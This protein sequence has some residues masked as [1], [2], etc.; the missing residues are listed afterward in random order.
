M[1]EKIFE[2]TGIQPHVGLLNDAEYY[3]PDY[4]VNFNRKLKSSISFTSRGCIRK[5]K[6]CAVK[7]L[8][9][10]FFVKNDWEK[11][12]SPSLPL[13]TFWDNNWLA[14]PNLKSD[15]DKLVQIGKRVDFNQ[16][17]DARLYTKEK[18]EL[19][20]KINLDPIRFAFDNLSNEK[21]VLKAIR[22]AK[23]YTNKEISS[24]VLYNFKDSPEE[25]FYKIN[26]LNQEGV[27][28]FPMGYREATNNKRAYP[29]EHWNNYLLRALK[30]SLLFYYR[31]GMIT[32]SRTSFLDIYG[33]TFKEFE[34]KLY[35]IYEYDKSLKR[36]VKND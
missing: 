27:L 18:A 20:A 7:T 10:D 34:S 24:Y 31:G 3:P 8:E 26:L 16:G 36:K 15:V 1:P 5:C 19:L 25:F 33:S 13:L 22:L 17:I 12:V 6:F 29:N 30:L 21:H 35:A 23:K 14:S 11:D 2:S 28:V 9:P 4:S 32:K